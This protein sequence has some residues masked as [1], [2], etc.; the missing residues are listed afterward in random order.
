MAVRK[1]GELFGVHQQKSDI[2]AVIAE[3]VAAA[4]GHERFERAMDTWDD[5]VGR[6]FNRKLRGFLHRE[7]FV[8]KVDRLL[9]G[10]VYA[11]KRVLAFLKSLMLFVASQQRYK[12]TYGKN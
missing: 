9:M 1:V 4:P 2:R 11:V 8:Q 12:Q 3:R 10:G 6:H 5:G 7:S